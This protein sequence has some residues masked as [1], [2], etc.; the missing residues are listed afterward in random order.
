MLTLACG[1]FRFFDMDLGFIDGIARLVDVGQCNDAF[2]AIKIVAA[3]A[4]AFDC[5][6]NDLPLHIRIGP[7]RPN[8]ISPNVLNVP[9]ENFN[10]T[11]DH[12]GRGRPRG[13]TRGEV[14]SRTLL[15]RRAVSAR[16]PKK[17]AVQ[18]IV[19]RTVGSDPGARRSPEAR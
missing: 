19:V 8:F 2:S 13:H 11:P 4:W 18:A 14:V 12:D 17:P 9:A 16:R 10:L 3:L 5:G 15:G 6:L 1:K 7:S